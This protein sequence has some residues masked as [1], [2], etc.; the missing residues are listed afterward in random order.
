MKTTLYI[1]AALLTIW[2]IFSSFL[3]QSFDVFVMN[4]G[5]YS[6]SILVIFVVYVLIELKEK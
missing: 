6:A 4:L 2:F 1:L 5:I 3:D